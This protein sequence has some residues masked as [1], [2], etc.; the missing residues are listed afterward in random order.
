MPCADIDTHCMVYS[1]TILQAIGAC[2]AR[3]VKSA[4]YH[5]T[6]GGYV[7]PTCIGSKNANLDVLCDPEI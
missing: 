6:P 4:P 5:S 2:N 7:I 1:N 3:E